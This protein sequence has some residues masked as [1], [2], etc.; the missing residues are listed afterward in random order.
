MTRKVETAMLKIVEGGF[1]PT[2][3]EFNS[4]AEFIQFYN[5]AIVSR[6][7]GDDR[8]LYVILDDMVL[9]NAFESSRTLTYSEL[10]D[11]LFN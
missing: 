9:Y 7:C 11:R 4:L 6:G 8:L 10:F 3:Y 5:R 2:T 1:C